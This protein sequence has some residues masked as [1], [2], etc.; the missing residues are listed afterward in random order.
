VLRIERGKKR[1]KWI[2]MPCR[3]KVNLSLRA[4]FDGRPRK[5]K[6]INLSSARAQ[7]EC[8]SELQGE[9][10]RE[11]NQ[12]EKE[13]FLEKEKSPQFKPSI[14]NDHFWGGKNLR[15]KGV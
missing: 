4:I 9:N 13:V 11:N 2:Q 15:E 10:L 12:E 14:V 3:G 8:A 7:K 5:P 1:V 6:V